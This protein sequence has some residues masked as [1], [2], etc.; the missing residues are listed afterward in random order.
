MVEA[1]AKAEAEKERPRLTRLSDGSRL[2]RGAAGY[3]AVW[4]RGQTLAGTK[5]DM[6]CNQEACDVQCAALVRALLSAPRRPTTPERITIFTDAKTAIMRMA[7]EEPGP[8]Q[9]YAIQARKR[10]ATLRR[11]RPGIIVEIRWWPA[12]KGV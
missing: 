3:S 6:D 5:T 4:K 10:I 2:N 8:G 7:S 12:H 1:E 9:Q 11:A